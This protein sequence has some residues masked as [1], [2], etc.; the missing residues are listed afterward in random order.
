MATVLLFAGALG[1]WLV[2]MPLLALAA[3]WDAASIGV[4]AAISAVTHLL[5][6]SRMGWLLERVPDRRLVGIACLLMASPYALLVISQA[7]AAFVLGQLLMGSARALFWT[8]SQTHAVRGGRSSVRAMAQVN[9]VGSIGQVSGPIVAGV[10]ISQSAI[11]DAVAA[12]CAVSGRP[13]AR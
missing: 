3:G 5:A 8:A 1:L 7:P 12:K 4:L 11:G 10:L 6:R 13:V 9:V 2:T